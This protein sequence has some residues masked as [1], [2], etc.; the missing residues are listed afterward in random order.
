[1]VE[2]L[3]DKIVKLITHIID[4][5]EALLARACEE[6]CDQVRKGNSIPPLPSVV[7]Q[8]GQQ[9][10]AITINADIRIPLTAAVAEFKNELSLSVDDPIIEGHEIWENLVAWPEGF[11]LPAGS[12]GVRRNFMMRFSDA[13][14]ATFVLVDGFAFP[15]KHPWHYSRRHP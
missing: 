11:F 7:L 6:F 1:M 5:D 12:M 3:S 8:M 4:D 15:R 2:I 13:P 9:S 14:R 10:I